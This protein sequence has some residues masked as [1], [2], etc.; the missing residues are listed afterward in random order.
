MK[1]KWAIQVVQVTEG[2]SITQIYGLLVMKHPKNSPSGFENS[3][4]N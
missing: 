1:Q 4:R 3:E 2:S